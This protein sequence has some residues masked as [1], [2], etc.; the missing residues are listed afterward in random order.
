MPELEKMPPAILALLAAAVPAEDS[1]ITTTVL[2]NEL[3]VQLDR[4]DGILRSDVMKSEKGSSVPQMDE[5]SE[6]ILRYDGTAADDSWYEM[7]SKART[8]RARRAGRRLGC[9]TRRRVGTF[10]LTSTRGASNS[11]GWQDSTGRTSCA[12]TSL[13]RYCA[14]RAP[15]R[16]AR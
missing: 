8:A 2:H 16:T 6:T 14:R 10:G 4:H 7:Y 3:L 15:P 1:M 9:P 11:S 12:P 13:T 5:A